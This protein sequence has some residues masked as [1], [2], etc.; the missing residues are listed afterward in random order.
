MG[1]QCRDSSVGWGTDILR[2]RKWIESN[3]SRVG[4]VGIADCSNVDICIYGLHAGTVPHT[5]KSLN[6]PFGGPFPGCY[7]VNVNLL[8]SR[9]NSLSYFLSFKPA[10]VVGGSFYIYE[11]SVHDVQRYRQIHNLPELPL[12][13]IDRRAVN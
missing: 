4:E 11:L 8:H 10:L 5:V 3:K 9:D 12:A 6:T 2:L 13:L 1:G 7:A